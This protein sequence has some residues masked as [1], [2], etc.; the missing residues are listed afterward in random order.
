MWKLN[1]AGWRGMTIVL[2]VC[3]ISAYGAVFAGLAVAEGAPVFE[4][5]VGAAFSDAEIGN[6]ALKEAAGAD[7]GLGGVTYVGGAWVPVGSGTAFTGVAAFEPDGCYAG[8]IG[9]FVDPDTGVAHKMTSVTGVAVD[10]AG[11]VWVSGCWSAGATNRHL[12][13]CFTPAG[14]YVR[15]VGDVDAVTDFGRR[16]TVTETFDVAAAPD[17][18]VLL[19]GRWGD[20]DTG[21]TENGVV[22][23]DGA[24]L[25]SC[26]IGQ[27]VSLDA[28]PHVETPVQAGGVA[29][30]PD[31]N[32]YIAGAWSESFPPIGHI[33]VVDLLFDGTVRNVFIDGLSTGL[34]DVDRDSRGRILASGTWS[35]APTRQARRLSVDG[36][37]VDGFADFVDLGVAH[38]AASIRSVA[39]A[40]NAVPTISGVSS[41]SVLEGESLRFSVRASDRETY[42]VAGQWTR[43]DLTRVQ[44]ASVFSAE[45]VNAELGLVAEGLPPG[46][47]FDPATGE[48]AWTPAVGEEGVYRLTFRADD[49]QG[50]V[51]SVMDIEV[52][53]LNEPP[54]ALGGALTGL[55]DEQLALTLLASDPD[56]D[57]LGYVIDA[58]PEHGTLS[59]E[60][61]ALT[62]TPDPDYNGSDVVEWHA[63]DG[64]DP[65]ARARLELTV[66]PVDDA[67]VLG[68]SATTLTLDEGT[69]GVLSGTWS[70]PDGESV[71]IEVEPYGIVAVEPDGTWAWTVTAE[72]GPE[73]GGT[74][75]FTFGDGCGETFCETVQLAVNPLPPT[76]TTV[77]P[78]AGPV[79]L[80]STAEVSGAFVDAGT[81]CPHA[82]TI[83]WGDGSSSAAVVTESSGS[84]AFAASHVYATPGLYMPSVTCADDDGQSTTAS[85]GYV[86]IYD[87][88]GGF[89]TGSGSIV[90][91]SGAYTPEDSSDSDVVGT[92]TFAFSSKYQKGATVPMGETAFAFSAGTLDFYS[93]SYEWL[94]VGGSKATYRGSGSVN[95]APGYRFVISAIDGG[96]TAPDRFRIRIWDAVSGVVL[97]DNQ[98]GASET[99][100]PVTALSAGN[101]LVKTK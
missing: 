34:T 22:R 38:S 57:P 76:L 14:G 24:G 81:W 68:F 53:A 77:A 82:V 89:T 64:T 41:R 59:G 72:D 42:A 9:A 101:I 11:L 85:L 52:L 100:D 67:P 6:Q 55:E 37:P 30:G 63:F 1:A 43:P 65:S 66:E 88:N 3:L 26:I 19:A 33:M 80:G 5:R 48:F 20:R 25:T 75:T 39:A 93:N 56:A 97:Y 29:A 84:G 74:V 31:G 35:S 17:G 58:G 54:V 10:E 15:R 71:D 4:R 62:Y 18:S 28:V 96:K 40:P 60:P 23:Y 44:G 79:P 73:Q 98:A 90:S 78:P 86:V 13:V 27:F 16:H 91:P 51:S 36:T 49:G 45:A 8:R 32:L 99:A 69:T 46:A 94:V 92:A 50:A 21:L 47:T 2:V 7:M 61:P 83:A 95:D 12:A 87:P 70:D